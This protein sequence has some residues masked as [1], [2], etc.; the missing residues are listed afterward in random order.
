MIAKILE[1]QQAICGVQAE[2]CAHWHCM[3]LPHNFT[4]LEAGSSVLEPL[5]VFTDALSGETNVTVSTI[6]PLLK[7]ITDKLLVVLDDDQR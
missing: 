7:H 3:P 1:Q 6:C 2:D 4:I 5:Q